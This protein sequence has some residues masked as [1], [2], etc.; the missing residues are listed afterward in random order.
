MWLLHDNVDENIYVLNNNIKDQYMVFWIDFGEGST[1][2]WVVFFMLFL[3]VVVVL[4]LYNLLVI[5]LDFI[6]DTFGDFMVTCFF[7]RLFLFVD[8]FKECDLREE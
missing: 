2:I 6:W 4:I 1:D 5:L 3:G 7:L 8:D